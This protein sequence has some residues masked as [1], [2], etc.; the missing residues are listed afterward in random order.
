MKENTVVVGGSVNGNISSCEFKVSSITTGRKNLWVETTQNLAVN[1]CTG[2]V[3]KAD[4]WSL[5]TDGFIIVI[6]G[7]ILVI[8]IINA[9]GR[10]IFD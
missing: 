4:S 5:T 7:F 8:C 6:L 3:I 9:I 1:N 2:E 10:S